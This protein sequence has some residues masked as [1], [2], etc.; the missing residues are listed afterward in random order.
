VT[1]SL[2]WDGQLVST[3]DY[4]GTINA[5]ATIPW[6]GIGAALTRDPADSNPPQPDPTQPVFVGLMDDIAI[7][8]RSLSDVELLGIY[9]GGLSG[10]NISQVPPV[11]NINRSPVGV[12]DTA[13]TPQGVAVTV[14]VLAN[15]TDPDNDTLNVSS[16]TSPAN[17][18][19]TVNGGGTSVTYTPNAGFFG[20]DSFTYRIGDGHGGIGSAVVRVT[21]TD[22]VPPTV[23]CPGDITA[24]ANASGNAVVTYVASAT[25]AGG[26]QSF[27]CVPPSGSTFPLGDTTVVC[28][29][30][31]LAGNTASCS[32]KVTVRIPNLPPIA[33]A[34]ATATN[35]ISGNGSNAVVH[36]DGT[37]SSDPDGDALIYS[38]LA[39]GN[40]VPIASGALATAVLDVGTHQVV[41][42]VDDGIVVASDTVEVRVITASEAVED[43]I[44]KVNDADI[45]RKTKRP[46]I[47][48]LKASSASFER[49]SNESGIN[50][51]AAFQNKV[52]AQIARNDPAL[53]EELIAAAQAIID[54]LEAP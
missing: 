25:D 40:P 38:W 42:V 6:L 31:D 47:A 52:R 15:D 39:D 43:L 37:R 22:N 33:D 23:N 20:T 29:A 32:F 2:Y 16:V 26:L 30:R 8:N 14:N 9:S 5:T 1:L 35:V 7:W 17:G 51:L 27:A 49:G 53:A 41:L 48:S 45:D 34:S 44:L 28:T 4:L 3:V 50:Q 13:T 36:L 19:A 54:A 11:L 21:V 24:D 10:Q 12:D 18:T 46:F